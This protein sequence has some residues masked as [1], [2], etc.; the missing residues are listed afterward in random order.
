[1]TE[2]C[3]GAI[4]NLKCPRYDTAHH[5]ASASL[6]TCMPGIEMRV[7]DD[8]GLEVRGDVVFMGYYRNPAATAEAFTP[9]GWFRTG[10]RATIDASGRLRLAGRAKEVININGV[11]FETT[12]VQMAVDQ[13]LGSLVGRSVVFSTRPPGSATEQVVVVHVPRARVTEVNT[14][15]NESEILAIEDREVRA[16][17]RV[18]LRALFDEATPLR[19]PRAILEDF[20]ATLPAAKEDIQGVDTSILSAGFTSMDLIRLKH[21]LDQRLGISVSVIALLQNPTAR[22][23]AKSLES[24]LRPAQTPTAAVE[25][26]SNSLQPGVGEVL[27][28]LNLAHHLATLESHARP[29]YAL[30]ARGFEPNQSRFSNISETVSA[31]IAA[32]RSRQ[33][34]WPYALAGYSYGTMLAFGITKVL[35][36][37]STVSFLGSF[38]LPPHIGHRMRQLNWNMCLLHLSYFLGLTTSD[39]A[40]S[41]EFSAPEYRSMAVDYEPQGRVR[42]GMDVFHA[43]PLRTAAASREEWLEV[44]LK[45]WNNFVG[46]VTQEGT[47]VKALAQRERECRRRGL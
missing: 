44:H 21:R 9:D 40:D 3:A 2:T 45:K 24:Q 30:R 19:I 15:S 36:E 39:Y 12:D 16:I 25:D 13:A 5:L 1:M 11:K 41:I 28:F 46:P 34:Q 35:Q 7:A 20:A 27:I 47:L 10:D 22:S 42:G 32:I 14:G 29:V 23:L 38:N 18:K 31:Y 33:P 37:T 26:A 17:S 8:G 6:G 43:I 4:Y